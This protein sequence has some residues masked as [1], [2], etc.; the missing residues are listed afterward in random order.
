MIFVLGALIWLGL[1][2]NM[3]PGYYFVLFLGFVAYYEEND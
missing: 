1:R 2:M 3:P